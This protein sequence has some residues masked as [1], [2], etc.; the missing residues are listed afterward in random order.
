M[1]VDKGNDFISM[2]FI[3]IYNFSGGSF[4]LVF[5]D[6]LLYLCIQYFWHTHLIRSS[7]LYRISNGIRYK[8]C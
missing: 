2:K 8:Q 5:I 3:I 7:L 1:D 4:Y 6:Q